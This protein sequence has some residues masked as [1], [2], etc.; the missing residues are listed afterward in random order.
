MSEI[1]VSVIVPCYNVEKYLARCM[2]S[3][4]NQTLKE[5]EIILVD[6]GSPDNCPMMC[7]DY[8]R[9]DARV[10]VI[11][12]EN[13]GLGFA[14]NSGLDVATGDYVVFCDSDDFVEK[15]MYKVLYDEAVHSGADVVFSNF[16]TETRKGTWK[17]N[18]E[19]SERREWRGK[20]VEAFMLDMVA[21][22]P[23]EKQERKYQMSVWHSIYRRSIITES[24]LRFYSEREVLSEDFPFQMDFLLRS[25]KV[26]FLPHAFYHYCLNE[27]SLTHSF[28]PD[29]F[30]RIQTLYDI[31]ANQLKS[32]AGSQERLDRFYIG[33]MRARTVE[34]LGSDARKKKRALKNIIETSILKEISN[35]YPSDNLPLYARLYY[36]LMKNN[37][38]NCLVVFNYMTLLL[39][40]LL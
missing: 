3:L 18:R 2:K 5:I 28:N 7:D 20:E 25:Q 15:E 22:A 30:E 40:R 33:Y 24:S 27:N 14:R 12:K 32:F 11:H 10:K 36:V 23:Y 4:L 1:K 38:M 17:V 9:Q 6:D 26:V 21:S 39:R 35:R 31:M 8:A 19:V 34:F 13:E 29:K 37:W 16:Y